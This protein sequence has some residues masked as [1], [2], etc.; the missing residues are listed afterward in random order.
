MMTIELNGLLNTNYSQKHIQELLLGKPVVR[1]DIMR[2]VKI[3]GTHINIPQGA[4]GFKQDSDG[5]WR[6]EGEVVQKEGKPS[7]KY[8][9]EF[10]PATRAYKVDGEYFER[11]IS[12]VYID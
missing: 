3:D 12:R 9:L 11:I 6:S 8:R 5:V 2:I 7:I 4:V 10:D 1:L